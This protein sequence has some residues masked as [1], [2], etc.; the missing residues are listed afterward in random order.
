MGRRI[1][2][3]FWRGVSEQGY[4]AT[5][6][7]R[8]DG[9][10]EQK[11]K[12]DHTDARPTA[13]RRVRR[14]RLLNH[15]PGAGRFFAALSSTSTQSPSLGGANCLAPSEARVPAAVAMPVRGLNHQTLVRPFAS[16]DRST[17]IVRA[18][19]R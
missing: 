11:G 6:P 17:V 2:G 1:G 8:L 12:S 3:V 9:G 18:V 7:T 10:G 14:W 4:W 13:T 5:Q 16:R 15:C 19:G